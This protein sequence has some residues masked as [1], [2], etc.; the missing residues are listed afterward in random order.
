MRSL[1]VILCLGVL[2]QGEV[3]PPLVGVVRYPSDATARPIYGVPASFTPGQPLRK[4]VLA[5]SFSNGGGIVASGG[6]ILV[7]DASGKTLAALDS[8]ESHPVLN[9]TDST[10]SALA[11][12]PSSDSLVWYDGSA[13]HTTAIA[14]ALPGQVLAC[15]RQ[16]NT[17]L[18]LTQEPGTAA[19]TSIDLS[20]GNVLREVS[21][22]E[23]TGPAIYTGDSVLFAGPDGLLLRDGQ[24]S[25]HPLPGN[26]HPLSF[27]RMSA[28][29]IHASAPDGEF[30]INSAHQ[31]VSQ[32][33][34]V[35]P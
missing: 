5:A 28:A 13:L 25:I 17:A 33:P 20:T 35:R 26:I 11:W 31:H 4:N 7:L 2:C 6:Q 27:E 23:V 10:S 16:Q 12:M 22:P 3:N 1:V 30:A 15:R 29:W 14:G 24:G 21:V 18:L 9:I 34:G 32:L 19:E 8:Q